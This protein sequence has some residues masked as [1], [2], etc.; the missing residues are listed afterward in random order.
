M[1]GADHSFKTLKKSGISHEEMVDRL[2]I[3]TARFAG[4]L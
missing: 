3:E 1:E 4:G 2:A